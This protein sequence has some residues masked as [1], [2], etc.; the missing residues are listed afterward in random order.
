MY[1]SVTSK[2][3]M[4]RCATALVSVSSFNSKLQKVNG[5]TKRAFGS[6]GPSL[7]RRSQGAPAVGSRVLGTRTLVK[8]GP[9]KCSRKAAE[10]SGVTS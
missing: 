3:K 10:E 6:G 4:K 7:Q 8:H 5:I 1:H 2:G 9:N